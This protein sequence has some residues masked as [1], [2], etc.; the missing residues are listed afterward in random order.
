MFRLLSPGWKKRGSRARSSPAERPGYAAH[1]ITP[2]GIKLYPPFPRN[3]RISP[4]GISGFSITHSIF[5][6]VFPIIQQRRLFFC[7]GNQQQCEEPK[8]SH[9]TEHCE[10]RHD[11]PPYNY[12]RTCGLKRHQDRSGRVEVRGRWLGA[13]LSGF[14]WNQ[15]LQLGDQN[16]KVVAHRVPNKRQ[17]YVEIDM[18]EAI[19]HADDL[20][21]GD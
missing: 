13:A 18:N 2:G 10:F 16:R 20:R 4:P 8:V 3:F 5:S 6:S 15:W 1:P 9:S 17:I 12:K 19:A 14:R 7:Q 21:P 11:R